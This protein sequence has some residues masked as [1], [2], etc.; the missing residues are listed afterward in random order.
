[1]T[2]LERAA[3][4]LYNLDP[5]TTDVFRR[6]CLRPDVPPTYTTRDTLWE[7]LDESTQRKHLIAARAVLEAIRE[8]SEAMK[9]AGAFCQPFMTAEGQKPFTPG[10]IIAHACYEAMIDAALSD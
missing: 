2:P 1:M 3:R 8:P 9:L 6:D 5:E 7:E 10:Q 4:A